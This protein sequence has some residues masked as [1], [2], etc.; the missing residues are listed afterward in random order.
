MKREKGGEAMATMQPPPPDASATYN[1]G[2]T[3][4]RAAQGGP[5]PGQGQQATAPDL[6]HARQE[7]A[8]GFTPQ[9]DNR[10][11]PQHARTLPSRRKR[12][13]AGRK[14]ERKTTRTTGDPNPM[15]NGYEYIAE[16]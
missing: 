15:L 9:P 16:T 14:N 2:Q 5:P 3:G 12:A 4:N 13:R 8:P 11:R 7:H 10:T 1:A 6:P